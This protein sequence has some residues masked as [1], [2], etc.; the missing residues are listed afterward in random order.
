MRTTREFITDTLHE[1]IVGVD[2]G[3]AVP[4]VDVGRAVEEGVIRGSRSGATPVCILNSVV[5][6]VAFYAQGCTG[7]S[8]GGVASDSIKI[9][10]HDP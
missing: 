8:P 9:S 10:I 1:R 5:K 7:S 4:Y 3:P 6:L 2:G